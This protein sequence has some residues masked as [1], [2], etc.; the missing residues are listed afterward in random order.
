M[1]KLP[2]WI[3]KIFLIGMLQDL[4]MLPLTP[5]KSF[6]TELAENSK[7]MRCLPFDITF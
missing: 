4:L 5:V 3:K 7:F 1:R 6:Y 2:S